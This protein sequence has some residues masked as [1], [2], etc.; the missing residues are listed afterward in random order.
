VSACPHPLDLADAD[1]GCADCR[2]LADAIA[3]AREL[4]IDVP[5]A[6][7]RDEVRTAILAGAPASPVAAR[8]RRWVVPAAA[9]VAAA[10]LLAVVR[11]TW[12]DDDSADPP[13]PRVAVRGHIHPHGGAKYVE[14]SAPPDHVIRLREGAIDVDVDPLRPGERFRVIVGADTIEVHGTSLQIMSSADYLTGVHVAH[15]HVEL[16]RAGAAAVHLTGG[17]TWHEPTTVAL[18]PAP[19]PAPMKLAPPARH[20]EPPHV[21]SAMPREA[22]AERP[23]ASLA[24]T[25]FTAGWDALRR[26]DLAPAAQAF[27]RSRALEPDGDLAEDAMFWHAVAIARLHRNAEAVAVLREFR[28]TY[29]HSTRKGT[30]ATMLGWLLVEANERSEALALFMTAVDD[31]TESVRAS[32]RAGVAAL[33]QP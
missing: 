16:R 1:A 9:V 30:V 3:I 32:A 23:P 5:A 21:A 17:Q 8:R 28:E 22:T 20:R 6:R 19:P 10:A 14:V 24:E 27:A 26:G 15:G 7:R 13:A 11:V 18:P 12:F 33:H 29:P 2:E 25:A 31:P 4:P